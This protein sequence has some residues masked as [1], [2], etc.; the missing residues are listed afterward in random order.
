MTHFVSHLQTRLS[1]LHTMYQCL[2][3]G[4][5]AKTPPGDSYKDFTFDDMTRLLSDQIGNHVSE[6]NRA[7]EKVSTT[8]LLGT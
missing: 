7:K 6:M 2:V 4:Q 3:A 1:F 5:P 8:D